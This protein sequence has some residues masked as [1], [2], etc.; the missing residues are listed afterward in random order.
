MEQ[1]AAS[2]T[3]PTPAQPAAGAPQLGTHARLLGYDLVPGNGQTTVTLYWEV[4][5]PLLPPHHIFV[6]LDAAT[7]GQTQAQQDGPP[8]TASGPAP[9]GSWQPGEFLATQHVLPATP[10]P[11]DVLRVGL[12]DPQT[13][14]R[15]PVTVDGQAAGDS[16]ALQTVE[17]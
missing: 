8:V 3:R 17:D 5:Q 7:D 11:G 6:H 9:T 14:V 13:Q 12:Y 10:G 16:V 2:F 4:L 1:R 15:L